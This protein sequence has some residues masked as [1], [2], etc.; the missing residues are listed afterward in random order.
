M[1]NTSGNL[2]VNGDTTTANSVNLVVQDRIIMLAN[3]VAGAPSAD[4]GLLF[5]R[6]NQ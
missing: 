4:V 6:G 5:N 1:M 3:S 2:V